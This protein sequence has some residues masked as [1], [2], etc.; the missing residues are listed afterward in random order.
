MPDVP[1]FVYLYPCWLLLSFVLGLYLSA[2]GIQNLDK[3]KFPLKRYK[4]L[5][6]FFMIAT[7]VG[8]AF[9]KLITALLPAGTLRVSGQMVL[10]VMTVVLVIVGV[11]FGIRGMRKWP[12]VKTSSMRAHPWFLVMITAL[13]FAQLLTMLMALRILKL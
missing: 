8:V 9:G 4:G 13:I 5:S 2:I 12:R 7:I 10:S 11:I 6:T 1:G 3:P